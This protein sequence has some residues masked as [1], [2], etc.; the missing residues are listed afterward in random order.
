MGII[1]KV[2]IGNQSQLR[3]SS[4]EVKVFQSLPPENEIPMLTGVLLNQVS[5]PPTYQPGKMIFAW[6]VRINFYLILRSKA[7]RVEF[8]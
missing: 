7:D 1:P 3:F 6:L 4:L 5:M 2:N 8:L